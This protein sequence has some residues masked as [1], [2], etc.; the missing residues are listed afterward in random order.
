MKPALLVFGYALVLAW[1]LPLPLRRLSE[2]GLSPRL[3]LTAWCVSPQTREDRVP[4]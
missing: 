3:G 2:A 4:L 1:V